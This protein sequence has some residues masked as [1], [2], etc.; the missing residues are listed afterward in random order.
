MAQVRDARLDVYWPHTDGGP[1]RTVPA[2]DILEFRVSDSYQAGRGSGEIVID[3]GDFGESGVYN[4]V[5]GSNQR[6]RELD[7][8]H[9]IEIRALTEFNA[10][11]TTLDDA[12]A[13][14]WTVLVNGV[15]ATLDGRDG[16]TLTLSIEDFTFGI[17]ARRTLANSFRDRDVGGSDGIVSTIIDNVPEVGVT[18]DSPNQSLT[19]AWNYEN[20]LEGLRAVAQRTGSIMHSDD[21]NT[22]VWQYNTQLGAGA[23]VTP[24]DYHLPITM[25]AGDDDYAN[26]VYVTGGEGDRLQV[27]DTST[28]DV[29]S[30]AT[31]AIGGPITLATPQISQ[32]EINIESINNVNGIRVRVQAWDSANSTVVDADN[33]QL[34]VGSSTVGPESQPNSG[35]VALDFDIDGGDL[36]GTEIGLIVEQVSNGTLS[37][38]QEN[39]VR[40]VDSDGDNLLETVAH[41]IYR[42]YPVLGIAQDATGETDRRPQE[43]RVR[44]NSLTTDDATTVAKSQLDR[45]NTIPKR[46][47]FEAASGLLHQATPGDVV[48]LT[49]DVIRANDDYVVT[50]VEQTYDA[51]QLDTTVTTINVSSL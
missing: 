6:V 42:P 48:T 27:E 17:L 25:T 45:M 16:A 43:V 49:N 50:D 30:L 14:R 1:D 4:A 35:W 18:G 33:R 2:G 32:I 20:L 38:G 7:I 34:D 3:N 41:R 36:A 24:D 39:E 10:S 29:Q 11:S 5:A 44:T 47:T 13:R 26:T 9:K 51:N 37:A 22:L 40:G 15:D 28:A 8:G 12:A 31:R 19:I 46:V 23:T 21:G